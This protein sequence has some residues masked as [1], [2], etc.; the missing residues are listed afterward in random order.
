MPDPQI[1]GVNQMV[2][3]I[4]GNIVSDMNGE[5]VMLSVKNGKYY[6]MGV[7]GGEIWEKIRNPVMISQV[8]DALLLEYEVSR[9]EC[10]QQV[11]SFIE[12]LAKEGLV[13]VK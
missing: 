9:D 13:E 2:A 11:V 3:Q 12:M 10:E 6:N 5:K 4:Q 7:I 1:I 8:V